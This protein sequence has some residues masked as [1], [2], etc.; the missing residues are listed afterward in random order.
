MGEE[1]IV[2]QKDWNEAIAEI[3]KLQEEVDSYKEEIRYLLNTLSINGLYC[4]A[5]DA[6]KN[7]RDKGE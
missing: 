1:F 7:Q 3:S 2:T 6:L 4:Q 5:A